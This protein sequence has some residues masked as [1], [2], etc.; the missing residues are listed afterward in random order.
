MSNAAQL[1]IGYCT[2]A[3][4]EQWK[5]QPWWCW[6][7]ELDTGF[8]YAGRKW[9]GKLNDA[10]VHNN[11]IQRPGSES[12]RQPA[13]LQDGGEELHLSSLCGLAPIIQPTI[14]LSFWTRRED[15]R[16]RL[17][18]LVSEALLSLSSFFSF[19]SCLYPSSLPSPSLFVSRYP[20]PPWLRTGKDL[21]MIISQ[22]CW[23]HLCGFSH[24]LLI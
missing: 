3:F 12:G 23:Y 2:S 16:F 5:Q 7:W 19:L 18:P 4:R 17:S 22:A 10:Q 6:W 15:E 24:L 11:S 13:R 9:N 1:A 21:V 20:S 8:F 14:L